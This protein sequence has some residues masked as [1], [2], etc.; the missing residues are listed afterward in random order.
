MAVSF[1]WVVQ[2]RPQLAVWLSIQR[3]STLPGIDTARSLF[4][5]LRQGASVEPNRSRS[6]GE[7]DAELRAFGLGRA[8][9][10]APSVSLHEVLHD[11]EPEADAPMG[12]V[13]GSLTALEGLEDVG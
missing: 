5:R 12:G 11:V 7:G 3:R 9:R 8:N 13:E 2:A 6:A 1:S 4:R 10:D